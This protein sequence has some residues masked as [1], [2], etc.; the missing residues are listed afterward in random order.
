MDVLV[1]IQEEFGKLLVLPSP[2]FRRLLDKALGK[3]AS[4]ANFSAGLRQRAGEESDSG[5]SEYSGDEEEDEDEQPDA[6][7][8]DRADRGETPSAAK[9]QKATSGKR[10]RDGSE[11]LLS[12]GGPKRSADAIKAKTEEKVVKKTKLCANPDCPVKASKSKSSSYCSNSCA[13]VSSSAAFNALVEY[14]KLL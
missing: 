10:G 14:R 6:Y 12:A 11:S 9:S 4:R 3:S 2:Q 8:K 5:S 1:K 7:W 13:V